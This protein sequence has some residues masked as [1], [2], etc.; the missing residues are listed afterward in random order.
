M[1]RR[2]LQF[3]QGG[4]VVAVAGAGV[5]LAE[6]PPYGVA[7]LLVVTVIL[8]MTQAADGGEPEG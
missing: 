6:E 7:L 1:S 3:V 4:C 5:L 8:V 2:A